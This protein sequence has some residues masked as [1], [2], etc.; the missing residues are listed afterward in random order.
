MLC[1]II[2]YRVPRSLW[3]NIFKMQQETEDNK[4]AWIKIT[5]FNPILIR[6]RKYENI[7]HNL[8][9]TIFLF[10]TKIAFEFA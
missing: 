2:L 5:D 4:R 7:F 3:K 10:G 1:V 9:G 6:T 8:R